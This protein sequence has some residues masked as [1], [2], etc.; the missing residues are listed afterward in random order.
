MNLFKNDFAK[1]NVE[2]LFKYYS[3]CISGQNSLKQTACIDVLEMF[4]HSD[5]QFV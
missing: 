3:K 1:V 4:L 5:S 2:K